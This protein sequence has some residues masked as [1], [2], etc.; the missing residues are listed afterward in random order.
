M[1]KKIVAHIGRCKLNHSLYVTISTEIDDNEN[2][3]RELKL[4]GRNKNHHHFIRRLN[5]CVSSLSSTVV[6]MTTENLS[7]MMQMYI[8]GQPL[9]YCRVTSDILNVSDILVASPWHPNFDTFNLWKTRSKA[10]TESLRFPTA[11][12]AAADKNLIHLK[13]DKY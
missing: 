1:K 12:A 13:I 3:W 4:N 2:R 11:M 8:I 5:E 10:N 9:I 7:Q 6:M